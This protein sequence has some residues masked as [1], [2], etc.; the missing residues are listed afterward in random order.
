MRGERKTE[1][2]I[3]APESKAAQAIALK[4]VNRRISRNKGLAKF[5]LG[6]LMNKTAQ[7]S[8]G[9]T[10]D[11]ITASTRRIADEWT[12][13]KSTAEGTANAGRYSL[14]LAD[15]LDYALQALKGGQAA[16]DLAVKKAANKIAATIQRKCANDFFLP[17]VGVPFPELRSR[18]K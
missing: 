13:T 12:W 16:V 17:P 4:I 18:T 8:Q 11:K 14:T 2:L 7:T 1:Y 10:A 6:R 5:A 15:N 3:V 9:G